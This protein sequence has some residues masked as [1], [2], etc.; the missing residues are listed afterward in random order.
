MIMRKVNLMKVMFAA[1]FLSAMFISSCDEKE[2][3]PK[4]APTH[5]D[6]FGDVFVKKVK[7]PKGADMY[8][9]VFY[10]GGKDLKSCTVKSPDGK[11]FTLKEFWKGAGNLRKHPDP[12]SE[13]KGQMPKSG[14]YTFDL[15]FTDGSKK[16]IV[17]ELESTEIPALSKITVNYADGKVDVSWTPV[18]GVNGYMVKLTDKDKNAKKPIFVNKA[19]KPSDKSFSFDKNTKSQPGWM[20]DVPKKGDECYV[21][22]VGMRFEN[23]FKK[24]TK[25]QNKQMNTMMMKKI[26]W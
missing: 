12:K 16:Q 1:I 24:E 4:P 13:M 23:G 3:D 20:K 9:L 5:E 11:D 10:A 26:V 21:I 22:V 8:G 6:A 25:D 7:N 18:S 17:D 15:T 14:K 2:D 19:L